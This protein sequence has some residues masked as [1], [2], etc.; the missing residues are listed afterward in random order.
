MQAILNWAARRRPP[1]VPFN[2]VR[3]YSLPREDL[4]II[5]PPTPDEVTA[6][7]KHASEH[8]RRAILLSYYLGLRP[9]A[10][11]L[12]GLTW[13][14][15]RPDGTILVRSAAKGGPGFRIVPVHKDLA[16]H[17][18]YWKADGERYIIHYTGAPV[19]SLKRTWRNTL[20]RAGITRRLRM[21][22]LRHHFV[23][24]ALENGMP[25]KAVSEIVGSRPETLMRHYQHVSSALHRSVVASIPTAKTE[26]PQK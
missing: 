4:E 6:I 17:L 23:T 26:R 2:P 5:L 25:I 11:E 21:Y 10:T 18:E 14:D 19:G 24:V 15:V 7:L 9:G 16:A 3:G 12:L 1:L 13:D 22:D 20:R 8:L